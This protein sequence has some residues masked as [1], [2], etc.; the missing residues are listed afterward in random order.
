MCIFNIINTYRRG[1]HTD[2]IVFRDGEFDCDDDD[3][4][5]NK[6]GMATGWEGGAWYNPSPLKMSPIGG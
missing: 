3:D 1:V 4:D 6:V 2:F 5:N